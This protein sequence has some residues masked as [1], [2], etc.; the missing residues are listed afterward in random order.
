M[1][2]PLPEN[3]PDHPRQEHGGVYVTSL[4]GDTAPRRVVS[5]ASNATYNASGHLVFKRGDNLVAAP[6]DVEAAIV[7]R[8]GD[9]L[10]PL[11]M[12]AR[13]AGKYPWQLAFAVGALLISA[14]ITSLGLPNVLRNPAA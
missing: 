1:P 3:H 5:D 9:K 10:G 7:H 11:K 6:F 13:E 14:T 2:L 12:I 4:S 8:P